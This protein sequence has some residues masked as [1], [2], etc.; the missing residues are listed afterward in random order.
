MVWCETEEEPYSMFQANLKRVEYKLCYNKARNEKERLFTWNELAKK[1]YDIYSNITDKEQKKVRDL[2][3]DIKLKP[4]STAAEKIMSIES[5]LKKNFVTRDDIPSEDADDMAKV[6][7]NKIASEK[8][9]IKLYTS[10]YKAADINY[11]IVL[12]GNRTNFEVDRTFENWNNT[13][14]FLLYFPATK[15][16]LAPTEIEYRYPWIPPTWANTNGLFC[17]GTTIGNFTTAVAEVKTIPLENYEHSFLNMDM[18][19]KLDKNDALL[20][21]VKQSYGGY[22]APNYRAPFVFLPE[23][24]QDKVLKEMIK[25]GTNSEN[26]LSH[27]YENKDLDQAEPYKPF[28]INASVRSNNLIERAGEKIIIF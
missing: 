17:V 8:A 6:I 28:V 11:Q 3:D 5:Y 20:I 24:E 25:F 13:N 10:L 26:I 12:C 27:S 4:N 1:A 22:A 23:D 21:D 15:K 7:K 2:L 14:N 18:N 9:I 16:F 19:L